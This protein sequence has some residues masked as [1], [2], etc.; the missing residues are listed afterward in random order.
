V[1]GGCNASLE[2][3][4]PKA[5]KPLPQAIVNQMKAKGMSKTSP[6][7]VRIFKEEDQLEVWKQKDNGRYDII[8]RLRHLHSGRASSDRNSPRATARR[9]R[10]STRSARTR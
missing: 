6:I 10:A 5:E 8:A 4:A 3:I 2:D 9:R 7:M 1:L